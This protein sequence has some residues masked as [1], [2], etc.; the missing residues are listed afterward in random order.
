M[1]RQGVLCGE[2]V[3]GRFEPHH[4]FYMCA[5]FDPYRKHVV[6]LNEEEVKIYLSGNVLNHP[7]EKGYVSLTY[8]GY[9]LGFGKSDG[10]MIKN[11]YP[12]GLRVK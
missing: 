4:H 9:V 8:K 11:K 10:S 2:I 1:L 12:K 7:C 3:K 6:E 5:A